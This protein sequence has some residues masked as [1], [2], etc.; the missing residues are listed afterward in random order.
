MEN[1][2]YNE[3]HDAYAVLR[4]RDFRYFLTFRFFTTIAFQMQSII[5]GWQMYELTKDPFALGLIGLAEALP[6]IATALFAGHVADRY[7]RKHIILI[8]TLLFL[9]GTSLLFL[10]SIKQLGIIALF[11]VIPIYGVVVISG[12]SR[13]FLYPSIIALMSQLVP[14]HLYTN[15]STWN[16]T[17]WHIGAITGPAI[18]GLVYG[19]FGVRVAY[20]SVLFFL[21]LALL[22]LT[23]VK[24]HLVPAHIEGETLL[25]R[26]SS[27]LKFVFKNQILLGAMS[28]DMFAVLFGGAVAMLPVFAAE[29]LKV[30]PQGLGFLRA[31]PMV[32]A[33]MMSLVMA[34]RPP[35][36]HAGRYLMIGVAGFGLSIICFALSRN[37]YLSLAMLM[38]SGMFDNIS[39]IIRATAMQLITPDAMRGRVAAVN[40]IFIGS[41]NEIGSF[42]SGL[43]AKLMGLIPSV[44]FGGAMTLVI[45]GI[46]AKKAPRLRK[47]NLREIGQRSES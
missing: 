16:S 35:M 12:I 27:G 25:E 38:L 39:V 47:L 19:F 33:V 37:F 3:K 34:H 4:V 45:V 5:V 26:L 18:G 40:S 2:D 9:V 41:S 17:I 1:Q 7:N 30:G 36:V 28:L 6:N 13:A 43:A 11:G 21:L 8:F 46:T 15:S 44:I 10:I 31:S 22:L 24:N 32:G 42:E 20:L 14:R 29:V 23:F